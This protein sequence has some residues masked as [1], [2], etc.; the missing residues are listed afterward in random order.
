MNKKEA[1]QKLTSLEKRVKKQGLDIIALNNVVF[2]RNGS[3]GN[4][5][6]KT[7]ML[8]DNFSGYGAK[9]F[10]LVSGLINQ[11]L[12][13]SYSSLTNDFSNVSLSYDLTIL[14]IKMQIK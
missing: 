14:S 5:L 4:I 10:D 1:L 3:Q 13:R 9:C 11:T 12:L 8:V 6:Y 7:G 2:D